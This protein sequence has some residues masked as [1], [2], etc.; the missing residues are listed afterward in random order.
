VPQRPLFI[1]RA[2]AFILAT[3]LCYAP[4][5]L[6][7]RVLTLEEGINGVPAAN[8]ARLNPLTSPGLPYKWWKPSFAKGKRFLFDCGTDP[9]NDRLDMTIKDAYLEREVNEMHSKLLRGEQSFLLSYSNLKDERRSL[10]KI[11][12]GATRLFDC[13]PLHY[14]IECRRFFGAFIAC[15]N[16][17]CTSLPSAVGMNPTGPD[18]TALYN[19]LNRFGGQVIAG[20]Y[21]AWDGKLDPDVMFAAVE[22]VNKWYGDGPENARARHTLVEQMIHLYTVYG[23]VVSLKSQGIPSG[24]PITADLNSLCNW[25]YV[26]IALQSVASEKGKVVDF[27]RLSDQ[28]ECVFY[29]DDHVVAPCAEIREWFSFHDV[30]KYFLSLGIGYTDALKRGGAQPPFMALANE[31][32]FLK[33]RFVP[34]PKRPALILAPIETKTIHEEI[35]WIRQ[36]PSKEHERDLVYQNLATVMT[37]S[38]HLGRA[39]Y[40]QLQR[41]INA[42]LSELRN[43]ELC[44]S[45]STQ[46]C[47]LTT[48]FEHHD[49]LWLAQFY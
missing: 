14:N 27:E 33:R 7:K 3:L 10:A 40:T 12:S 43:D 1:K 45:G 9:R 37:E 31:T 30:Q 16:Q 21:Q 20:D 49:E 19:R 47:P 28:L 8:F 18:W 4:K 6:Q 24:V 35:N 22:V 23:N 48:D 32:T 34:H 39:Y 36:C 13:M 29:G 5:G 26:L 42:C 25:F 46:W 38:Y 15:M 17:N 11:R 41:K 44:L 2:A